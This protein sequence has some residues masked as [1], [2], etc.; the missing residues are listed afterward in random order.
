MYNRPAAQGG[1]QG[2]LFTTETTDYTLKLNYQLSRY[3]TL[4]FMTQFGRKRQPYR[5]GSGPGADA[6]LVEPMEE[7]ELIAIVRALLRVLHANPPLAEY[8]LK[9]T[10]VATGNECGCPP[11][12]R[13][14]I[15]LDALR[16]VRCEQVLKA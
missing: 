16:C 1:T 9:H 3:N 5:F 12:T 10:E 11:G 8:L 4:S 13:R 14:L 2:Q 15:Q 7:T 6:Y